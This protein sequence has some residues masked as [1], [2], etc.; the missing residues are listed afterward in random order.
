[1]SENGVEKLGFSGNWVGIWCGVC[2]Y[3]VGIRSLVTESF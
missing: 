2:V 3:W 1:M